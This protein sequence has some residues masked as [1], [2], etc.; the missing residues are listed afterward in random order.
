VRLGRVLQRGPA[1]GFFDVPRGDVNTPAAGGE[2]AGGVVQI[3]GWC[4]FPGSSVT[5]VDIDLGPLGTRRARLGMPRPDVARVCEHPSAPLS[6]F[7]CMTDLDAIA[8]EVTVRALAHSADGRTLALE[9]V[10]FTVARQQPFAGDETATLLRERSGRFARPRLAPPNGDVRVLAFSHQLPYGG[11]SL[12]MAEL[13][14]RL[15]RKPGF[16][17]TV[18]TLQDG[19]LRADLEAAGIAVHLAD[20][21]PVRTVERY[22][23]SVAELMAW[24]APQRFDVAFVNTLGS[25][26]GADVAARLG[27]PVVWGVHESFELPLF[28]ATAYVPGSLHPYVMARAEHAFTEAAAVVFEAEATRRLFVPYADPQRLVTLPYGIELDAVR[29]ARESRDRGEVRRALGIPEGA[30]VILCLGTLEARKSQAMLA[31]AFASVADGHPDVVLALVG[32]VD[33]E[34][35]AGYVAAIRAFLE[36]RG[37][38]TRVR[39]EPVD[40][41]PYRW[42]I[43]SDVHVCASDVES[44]PRSV[45]EAMAFGVPVVSTDVFG[46]PEVIEDGVTGYLCATRDSAGLAHALDRALDADPEERAR[47]TRTAG[48]LVWG[49]H[50]PARYAERLWGLFHALAH[51]PQ[52]DPR[53]ALMLTPSAG[54]T[55]VRTRARRG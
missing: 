8:G 47:I 14:G 50:E 40:A 6:G 44:L 29:A 28:W 46:I 23:A 1:V 13:L 36:R 7:E 19:P 32:E 41:D 33:A 54:A 2:V 34:W 55:S 43:A 15:A 52:A 25:F 21:Y 38:E 16:D 9:P 17:C 30:R 10:T 5:R 4:L 45:L 22:E 37:L 26:Q 35:C 3:L 18:V 24:A 12:Y 39:I 20:P 48:A 31:E 49:R 53:A 42:H 27:I 11:A 51:D